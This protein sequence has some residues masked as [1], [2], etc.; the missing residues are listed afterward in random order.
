VP[1][2]L[3]GSPP[4]L[5]RVD[6]AV[7]EGPRGEACVWCCVGEAAGWESGV[8]R[9]TIAV[10]AAKNGANMIYLLNKDGAC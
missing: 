7:E 8:S 6:G 3:A 9:V 5:D 1:E 10:A 4:V 2:P